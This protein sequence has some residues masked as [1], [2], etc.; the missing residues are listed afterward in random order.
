MI[1]PSNTDSSLLSWVDI[2]SCV[3]QEDFSLKVSLK[4]VFPKNYLMIN[5]INI[6][7]E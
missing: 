3:V 5:I 1:I 2:V 6:F 7:Y 4:F